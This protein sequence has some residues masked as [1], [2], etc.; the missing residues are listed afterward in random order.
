MTDPALAKAAHFHGAPLQRRLKAQ[1][2]EQAAPESTADSA[3][4]EDCAK[5]WAVIKTAWS[6][7]SIWATWVRCGW[8]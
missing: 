3:T 8:C 1:R 6:A 5:A 4:A 2:P 7:K